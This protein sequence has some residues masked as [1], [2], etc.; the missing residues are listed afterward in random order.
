[1]EKIVK[2]IFSTLRIKMVSFFFLL[3]NLRVVWTGTAFLSYNM[4]C[5]RSILLRLVG[6]SYSFLSLNQLPAFYSLYFSHCEI[7]PRVPLTLSFLLVSLLV[8]LHTLLAAVFLSFICVSS[9]PSLSFSACAPGVSQTAVGSTL[10]W[11]STSAV[12]YLWMIG[13]SLLTL[14]LLS[15]CC[16]FVIVGLFSFDCSFLQNVTYIHHQETRR[17]LNY[18]LCYLHENWLTVPNHQGALPWCF[19]HS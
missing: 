13:I 19:I 5:G 2:L 18:T 15:P 9:L 12:T 14:S 7:Y 6:L 10:S 16:T 4:W 8:H 1:M 17:R 11:S 3:K